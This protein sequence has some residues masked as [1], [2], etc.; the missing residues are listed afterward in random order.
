MK[1]KRMNARGEKQKTP[2]GKPAEQGRGGWLKLHRKLRGHPLYKR[3][4][5]VQLWVHF[6]LSAEFRERRAMFSGEIVTLSPGQFISSRREI[7]S[8]TLLSEGCVSRLISDLQN[9]QQIDQQTRNKSSMFTVLNW[10]TYQE[11]DPQLDPQIDPQMIH[12]RSTSDPQVIHKT[13]IPQAGVYI[14]GSKKLRSLEAKKG[15]GILPEEG[16][17]E[18]PKFEAIDKG[19]FRHELEAM[20]SQ[21]AQRIETLKADPSN[22]VRTTTLTEHAKDDVAW[23]EEAIAAAQDVEPEK[24]EK[25]KGELAAFLK[26]PTSYKVAGLTTHTKVVLAAWRARVEEIEKSMMGVKS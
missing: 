3:K 7:A 4:G 22:V 23:M 5:F 20:L 16:G 13:Q 8:Q 9:D 15:G 1:K 2:A 18:V 10:S 21:C 19:L 6:L 14:K 24:A 25:I 17:T 26:K 11:I 12:K